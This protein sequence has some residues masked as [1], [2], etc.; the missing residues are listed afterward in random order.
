MMWALG[1]ESA[2]GLRVKGV[3]SALDNGR[4]RGD[5]NAARK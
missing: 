4:K 1:I 2:R 5:G 3:G